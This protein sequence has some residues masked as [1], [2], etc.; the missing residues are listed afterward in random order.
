MY[1][2]L[3]EASPLIGHQC[4]LAATSSIQCSQL[5]RYPVVKSL[6]LCLPKSQCGKVSLLSP[7]RYPAVNIFATP[8]YPVVRLLATPSGIA[9]WFERRTRDWKVAGSNHYRRGGRIFF[10]RINFLLWL[11]FRYPFHP[12]NNAVAR[13][14]SRSFCRKC[15]WQVTAKTRMHLTYVALH[16]VTWCMIVRCTQNAPRWQQFHVAPAMPAL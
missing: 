6:C 9:Q 15:R 10:S 14:R 1:S 8:R 2:A 16:E 3:A 11:W 7:C 4:P 13:K 5:S 12:C